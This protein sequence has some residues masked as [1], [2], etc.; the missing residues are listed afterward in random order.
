MPEFNIP[1]GSQGSD[2]PFP[3]PVLAHVFELYHGKEKSCT[4]ECHFSENW[5]RMAC[6]QARA[7]VSLL[8][9]MSRSGKEYWPCGGKCLTSLSSPLTIQGL[10]LSFEDCRTKR[11]LNYLL[12]VRPHHSDGEELSIG[13]ISYLMKSWWRIMVFVHNF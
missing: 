12:P 4:W 1:I 13:A 6:T 10:F 9:E 7:S 3:F 8:R 11:C 2:Q 5:N